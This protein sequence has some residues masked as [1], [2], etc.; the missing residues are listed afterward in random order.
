MSE[1]AQ[2]NK[3]MDT[4]IREAIVDETS[5]L[6]T[7]ILKFLEDNEYDD[8]KSKLE[9]SIEAISATQRRRELDL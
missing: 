1:F 5:K 8:E 6:N 9:D 7:C 4:K 3:A 2:P